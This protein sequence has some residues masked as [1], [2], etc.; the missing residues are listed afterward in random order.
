[1]NNGP[2]EF[3]MPAPFE[4]RP[5]K[6]YNVY[7]IQEQHSGL[8]KIGK[9]IDVNKRKVELQMGNPYELKLLAVWR[10]CGQRIEKEFHLRFKSD[11]VRGEW[12]K[13]S[14]EMTTLIE[15]IRNNTINERR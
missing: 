15:E 12:F 13:P 4:E 9:A 11:K 1:M 2:I 6:M 10:Q 3:E 5:G 14:D 8:I 7:F